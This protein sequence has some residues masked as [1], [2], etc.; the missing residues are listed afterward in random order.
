M[1]LVRPFAK[2][3]F[4]KK[5]YVHGTVKGLHEFAPPEIFPKDYEGGQEDS[6]DVLSGMF[7]CYTRFFYTNFIFNDFYRQI[8]SKIS[9]TPRTFS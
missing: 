7:F 4:A 5:L 6:I 3:E 8:L 9:G 1:A 2:N